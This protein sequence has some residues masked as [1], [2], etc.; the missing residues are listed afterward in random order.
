[1]PETQ[2]MFVYLDIW[3]YGDKELSSHLPLTH[4]QTGTQYGLC[5]QEKVISL[6][7]AAS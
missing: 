6:D 1:M 7:E 2:I 5:K 3:N 4:T